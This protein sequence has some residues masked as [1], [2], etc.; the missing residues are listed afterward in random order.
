MDL[1]LRYGAVTLGVELKVWRDGVPD[2]VNDGL[3]QLD[4]YL[5]GLGLDSGWLVIFDRR[6]DQPPIEARTASQEM[7]S[8]QGR[9]I[10]MV[11]A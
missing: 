2:P 5:S 7:T 1:C 3:T 4:C 8:P 10:Q 11:R 9:V 6:A